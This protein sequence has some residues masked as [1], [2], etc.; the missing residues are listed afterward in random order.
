MSVAKRRGIAPK[1]WNAVVVVKP[2]KKTVPQMPR[3]YKVQTMKSRFNIGLCSILFVALI[4]ATGCK[5]GEGDTCLTKSD[6]KPG[7]QCCFD[8]LNA[9]STLGV[10]KNTD[11]CTPVIDA[12]VDAAPKEDAESPQD[13]SVIPDA[14]VTEDA[15]T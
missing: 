15:S 10:C 3:M 4:M 14:E 8:G 5:Q 1:A 2:V 7:L 12:S 11:S 9:E 6:C 13:A